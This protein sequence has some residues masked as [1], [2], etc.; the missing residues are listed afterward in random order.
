MSLKFWLYSVSEMITTSTTAVISMS[1]S[2]NHPQHEEWINSSK[3]G[4]T[5]Q[6]QFKSANTVQY[7]KT[8]LELRQ[9][10]KRLSHHTSDVTLTSHRRSIAEWC[11]GLPKQLLE[12]VLQMQRLDRT[13]SH[14][15]LNNKHIKHFLTVE[16]Q[17]QEIQATE[18]G[19]TSNL[20]PC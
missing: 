12:S 15:Q 18:T 19:C 9:H 20:I 1:E 10:N 17:H 14:H 16:F 2:G 13:A 5:I 6:S 3:T 8:Q 4:W 11:Y 7:R